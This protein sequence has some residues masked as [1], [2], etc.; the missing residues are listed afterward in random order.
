MTRLLA[1]IEAGGTKFVCAL[2]TDRGEL[3]AE[4]RFPTTSPEETIEQAVRFLRAEQ[5]E[6]GEV[7]AVGI[8][9]FGPLDLRPRSPSYGHITSTPK[10]GWANTDLRGSV[11]QAMKVPVAIDTDVNAAALAEW[12]WGS[13]KGLDSVVYITIGT[14]IGGGV[15][16]HGRPVHGLVHPEMGHILIPH[17][18]GIDPFPGSCPFH[19][20]CLEGLASGPAMEKRWQKRA[21]ALPQDH[22]AWRLEA[23]YLA[24]GLTTIICSLSPERIILGGGVMQQGH[25]FPLIRAEAVSLMNG[26]VQAE[27]ILG[28]MDDYVVPPALG[29][30]AG[31]LGALALAGA[32]A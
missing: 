8:A 5:A 31:I 3:R 25:L 27:E 2:G 14:G 29:D 20:D 10:P 18:K 13:A 28:G 30:R 11:A 22:P 15:L 17:D 23:H 26:Y 12:R 9:A 32:L 24:L 4:A 7:A 21:E 6:L 16:I 19:G 1:G